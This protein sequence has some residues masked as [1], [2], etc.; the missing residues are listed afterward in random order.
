MKIDRITYCDKEKKQ[1]DEVV[2]KK[3]DLVH[4]E[5]MDNGHIWIALYSGEQ[6]LIVNYYTNRNG[7]IFGHAEC[8]A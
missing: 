5:R 3:V 1:L 6:R 4:I 8:N 7:Q 2:M